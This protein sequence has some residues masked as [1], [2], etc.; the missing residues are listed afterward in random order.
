MGTGTFVKDRNYRA[1]RDREI[2]A[3]PARSFDIPL[4]L[5]V[6]ALLVLGLIM[7][8]SASWDFSLGA[9]DD[10]MHMF[11][12]QLLWMIL[13][14]FGAFILM[15]IDYHHWRKLV[16]L[17]MALTMNPGLHLLVQQGYY[18]LATPTLATK[19]DVDHLD[20]PAEARE[21]IRLELYEAG[22]MMYL[23]EES[24]RKFR[25]DLARFVTETDRL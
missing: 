19:H 9:Y 11:N 14:V 25:D 3:A 17:A 1:E 23:H 21:R 18:D 13:G 16:I 20:V 5:T 12:R 8:Y 10:P 2:A 7:L 24:M 4:L 15:Q 22:H 6:L